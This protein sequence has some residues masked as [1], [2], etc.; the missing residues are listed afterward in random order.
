M[1]EVRWVKSKSNSNVWILKLL[2]RKSYTQL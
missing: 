1:P 2:G